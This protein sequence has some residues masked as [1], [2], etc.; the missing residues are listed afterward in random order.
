MRNNAN[1]FSLGHTD[2]QVSKKMSTV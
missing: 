2:A 1:S